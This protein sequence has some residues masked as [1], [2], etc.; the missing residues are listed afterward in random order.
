MAFLGSGGRGQPDDLRDKIRRRA[1]WRDRLLLLALVAA[2]I[3][4][5]MF[6]VTQLL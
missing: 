6:G 4:V 1:T 5:A 2:L 3:V